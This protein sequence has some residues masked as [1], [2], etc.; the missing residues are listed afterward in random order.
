MFSPLVSADNLAILQR[1]IDKALGLA[2]TRNVTL[3]VNELAAFMS[4]A[5][6]AGERDPEK[7]ADAVFAVREEGALH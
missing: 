1:A 7:L 2:A 5:F 4:R 3:T 6:E